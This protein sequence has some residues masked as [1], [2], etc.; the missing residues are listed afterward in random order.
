VK[1]EVAVELPTL[2]VGVIGPV[3]LGATVKFTVPLPVPE[4]PDVMEIWELLLGVA[5]H[6]QVL[7]VGVTVKEPVVPEAEAVIEL[8]PSVK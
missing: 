7:G 6:E 2:I 1:T 8:A 4:A 3:V 5:V